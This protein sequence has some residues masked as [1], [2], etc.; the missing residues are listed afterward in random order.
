[1]TEEQAPYIIDGKNVRVP[2][3]TKS[4]RLSKLA[5][6]Q[7]EQLAKIWDASLTETLT[8]IIDRAYQASCPTKEQ[9]SNE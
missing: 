7:L 1:M 2:K 6:S 9:P 8:L 3:K 4:Y 5:I